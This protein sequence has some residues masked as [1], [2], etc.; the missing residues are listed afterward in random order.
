MPSRVSRRA[1]TRLLTLAAVTASATACDKSAETTAPD[2]APD[3]APAGPT[4]TEEIIAAS[5]LPATVDAPLPDDD[6]AVT[7]HRL[8]NGMTV[9]ISTERQKPR[10]SAWVAVRTGSRNDPAASTGLAHYLEHMLF[11][12]T[13][14]LGTLDYEKE[15]P[16][17][18]RIAQL[19]DDLRDAD[20]AESR[21][22]IFTEIDAET[23]KS[24]AYAVPNEISRLYGAMGVEGL[25]A[26]TSFDATVYIADVP[27][28]RF[29]A[30]AAVE[31]VRYAD[32][33]FRLFLPEL[34][35][36]YE[37]KNRSIDSPFRTV[38]EKQLQ[39]LF[40]SH[41][42]GTQ[43][44]IGE[45][46]HLKVPAYGDMVRYFDRWYVP[47]N[48]AVVLAGDID[49]E[50][51]LPVL[52]ATLGKLEPRAL[53]APETASDAGPEG[54]Q[55]AEVE[56]EGENSVTLAWRTVPGAHA[57][58]A[59]LE[60]MDWVMD[61]GQ[62]GLINVELEL[63]QR[64]P[65]A[66]S[67][68]STM[69]EG[70]YWTIRATAKEGQSHQEVEQLLMGV[71]GRLKQGAFEQADVDSVILQTIKQDA[72]ALEFAQARVS[73]ME[74]AFINRM[75]WADWV[76]ADKAKREV[77]KEDIVRVANTYL[78]DDFVVVYRKK[79]KP[80]LP[81]IDKPKITP[82]EIDNTR[83]SLFARKIEDMP[84]TP[85]E[86]EWLEDG[87]QYTVAALP[88]GRLIAARNESNDLFSITYEFDRGTRQDRMLC[89]AFD[90]LEA[91]GTDELDAQAMQKKIYALG[92][93][94]GFG[95]S[96]D[97]SSIRVSGFDDKMEDTLA[98]LRGWI[99]N[100]KIEPEQL[101]RLVD[102]E[103]SRRRDN[104]E[105]PRWL[106]FALAEYAKYGKDSALLADPSNKQLQRARPAK[107]AKIIADAPDHQ[108]T[109]MYFGPRDAKA[110]AE[111]IA[112]GDDHA[113]VT[114]PAPNRYRKQKGNRIYFLSDDVAKSS[115]SIAMPIGVADDAE[116]PTARLLAEYFGGGM[117]SA[118][119]QEIR[120]AR[121]LA[122]FARGWMS[123]GSREGDDWAFTGAMD[124]QSDKT[125]EALQVY[126]DLVRTQPLDPAR[127]A[128]A[129]QSLEQEYRSSRVEPR[130]VTFWVRS[131]F[132]RGDDEDP[133]PEEREAVA[134]TDDAKLQ[135]FAD[136]LDDAPV[137][138]SVL[139]NGEKLDTKALAEVA[140]ITE[141][142]PGQLFS[143]G[144]FPKVE[145][146]DAAKKATKAK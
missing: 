136:R 2:A 134:A 127:T 1:I 34:E 54:R 100:V 64:V 42:Y 125:V 84:T 66:G 46:D 35:A 32:P 29:E 92:S 53:E 76:A 70:G 47:N 31:G 63:P 98:V 74:D 139:G 83:K 23:Q 130:F 56:V 89:L 41:P 126:L 99:A 144:A 94:I 87:K 39:L 86:P 20:T 73:K 43:T 55:F 142:K 57:D 48:M 78:A 28:N 101:E 11:K 10:I 137:I 4:S 40:P 24:A 81:K 33:V 15:K 6:M 9:Y 18:D 145:K 7:V 90:A 117:A 49:P 141:V 38:W 79:G 132:E 96:D 36:V 116:R 97:S 8:S 88:A 62:A 3:T 146:A 129:K 51:A 12:G 44:T 135:T 52:E 77:T 103:I 22:G 30:W 113:E 143:W 80:E 75:E 112:L 19:Y 65:D 119:F 114:P 102:N 128:E 108:H 67:S 59:A 131:W 13:T 133:R 109:T 82:V 124:T 115:V 21:A 45:V 14:Q 69:A 104:V 107:L 110:A 138:I 123:S 106:G 72:Q 16:H 93:S 121:G 105:D 25:N 120:E 37:E 50:T 111:A 58:A 91:S 140:P 26:F 60:V 5:N 85:L 61:N 118:I 71:V 95:C 122:Y 17:L 27:A 68:H